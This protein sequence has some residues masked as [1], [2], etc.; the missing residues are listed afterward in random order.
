[1]LCIIYCNNSSDQIKKKKVLLSFPMSETYAILPPYL[2]QIFFGHQQH[3]REV[4]YLCWG[5]LSPICLLYINNFL[6][7]HLCFTC[8]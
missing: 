8:L 6:S 1:M 4:W 2:P 7:K 3:W 5:L